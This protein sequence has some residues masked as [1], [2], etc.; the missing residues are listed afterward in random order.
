MYQYNAGEE[1]RGTDTRMGRPEEHARPAQESIFGVS[2]PSIQLSG[3]GPLT[4]RAGRSR[5]YNCTT[6]LHDRSERS[7][8]ILNITKRVVA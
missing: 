5:L 2:A 3:Y 6:I 1:G 4:Q 7:S 8:N